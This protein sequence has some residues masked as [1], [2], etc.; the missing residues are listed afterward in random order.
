MEVNIVRPF[1]ARALQSF[2]KLDSLLP[3]TDSMPNNQPQEADKASKGRVCS[4][5]VFTLYHILGAH[6]R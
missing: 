1:V 6:A 2:Q 4:Y 3:E 5:L